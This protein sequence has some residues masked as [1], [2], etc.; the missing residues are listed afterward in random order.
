MKISLGN[1]KVSV[2]ETKQS[3]EIVGWAFWK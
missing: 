3:A 2:T 1:T